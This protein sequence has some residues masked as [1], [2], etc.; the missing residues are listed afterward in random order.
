M[1]ALRQYGLARPKGTSRRVLLRG[2]RQCK[3]DSTQKSRTLAP[4]IGQSQGANFNF[5]P[6]WLGKLISCQLPSSAFGLGQAINQ[7]ACRPRVEH[8]VV[9]PLLQVSYDKAPPV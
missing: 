6:P 2:G 1:L 5:Q 3:V 8:I 4:Y 7:Q 9:S